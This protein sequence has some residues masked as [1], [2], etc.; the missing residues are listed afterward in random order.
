MTPGE[1]MQMFAPHIGVPANMMNEYM[2]GEPF[3]V[4]LATKYIEDYTIAVNSMG[5]CDREDVLRAFPIDVMADIFTCATGIEMT[6]H[7]M[8]ESAERVWAL[9]KGFNVREGWTRED[10]M[11]PPRLYSEPLVTANRTYPGLERE[12][13][14][15]LL[16]TYYSAH[17]W[18][19]ETGIPSRKR[20]AELDLQEIAEDLDEGARNGPPQNTVLRR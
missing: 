6:T 16:D 2:S 19:V 20:L 8:L 9:E 12:Y 17:G 14:E 13:V 5:V 7:E 1:V 18:D 4:P 3:N 15:G 10:D 11:G